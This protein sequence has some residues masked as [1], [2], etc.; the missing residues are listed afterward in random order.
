MNNMELIVDVLVE[1]FGEEY[2]E[3]IDNKIKE[4]QIE[5]EDIEEPYSVGNV[6]HLPNNIQYDE[7]GNLL[8]VHSL[9]HVVTNNSFVKDSK[10]M[11]NEIVI[12][13]MSE[14]ICEKMKEKNLN[15]TKNSNPNYKS[16]TFYSLHFN[17]IDNFFKNNKNDIIKSMMSDYCLDSSF[18]KCINECEI[19]VNEYQNSK[20]EK[21]VKNKR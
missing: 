6:I 12:D 13:Y 2:G 18:N 11:L 16:N 1:Y 5:F 19:Y 4:I 17:N 14:E 10:N 7:N 21:N 8:L 20:E 3:Y 9:L 15:L